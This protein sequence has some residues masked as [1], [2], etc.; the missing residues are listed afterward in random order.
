[1]DPARPL[2]PL[3][4]ERKI[5]VKP[6]RYRDLASGGKFP[7]GLVVS[8]IRRGEL[9]ARAQKYWA[10]IRNYFKRAFIVQ[11]WAEF[12]SVRPE[13]RWRSD[14]FGPPRSFYERG[15]NS[16]LM[17]LDYFANSAMQRIEGWHRDPQMFYVAPR[18]GVPNLIGRPRYSYD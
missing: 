1:M 12:T 3:R 9:R 5:I 15:L 6:S 14:Y 4:G 2:D 18:P 13:L 10:Y 7:R 17:R 16:R 8:I 11:A